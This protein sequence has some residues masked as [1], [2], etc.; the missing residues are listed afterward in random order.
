LWWASEHF[1]RFVGMM[2]RFAHVA[3]HSA[4]APTLF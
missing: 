3:W 1:L 4:L 2:A